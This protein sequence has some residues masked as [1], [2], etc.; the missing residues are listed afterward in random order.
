MISSET[1]GVALDALRANKDVKLVL[2][3]HRS[4]AL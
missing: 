4:S 1:W 3:A 2:A